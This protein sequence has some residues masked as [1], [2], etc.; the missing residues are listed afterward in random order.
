[1]ACSDLRND[2]E[3]YV[4]GALQDDEAL[5]VGRHI[6]A[7]TDCAGIVNAYRSVVDELALA[8]PVYKARPRLREMVLGAA[9]AARPVTPAYLVHSSRWWA[10]AAAVF[11]VF[12][13]GA[14]VWAVTLSMRSERLADQAAELQ[15]KIASIELE[16]ARL[17]ALSELSASDRERLLA[18]QTQLSTTQSQLSTT[19]SEQRR[20]ADS[21]ADQETLILLALDPAL[22]PTELRG[23]SLAPAASCRYV[24]SAERELGALTCS[25]LPSTNSRY[26]ELWMVR[27]GQLISGGQFTS[28]DGVAQHLIKLAPDQDDDHEITDIWVTLEVKVTPEFPSTDVVLVQQPAASAT[29]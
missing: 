13:I 20:L 24:W 8:V 6:E 25:R 26:F 12:G 28:Q 22:E 21:L 23:T 5:D 18:F 1:V 17:A 7:C 4:L 11:L 27:D 10:A 29:R 2:L 3:A 9:G 16:N 19:K 14:I 15:V